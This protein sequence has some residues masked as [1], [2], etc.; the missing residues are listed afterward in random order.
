MEV[1]HLHGERGSKQ[2]GKGERCKKRENANQNATI[3]AQRPTRRRRLEAWTRPS[4]PAWPPRVAPSF[5]SRDG[6][7][8]SRTVHEEGQHTP[9]PVSAKERASARRRTRRVSTQLRTHELRGQAVSEQRRQ[10]THSTAPHAACRTPH[11]TPAMP[12]GRARPLPPLGASHASPIPPSQFR[13]PSR[14]PHRR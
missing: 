13:L 1:P 5:P 9:A 4:W 11:A 8:C 14:S 3:H 12:C 10:G 2:R 7:S 6:G